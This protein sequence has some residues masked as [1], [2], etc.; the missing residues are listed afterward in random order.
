VPTNRVNSPNAPLYEVPLIGP[1]GQP[2]SIE[3]PGVNRM[4][5]VAINGDTLFLPDHDTPEIA[6]VD[7][8]GA[9]LAQVDSITLPFTPSTLYIDPDGQYLFALHVYDGAVSVV[10]LETRLVETTV[11]GLRFP[12][13]LEFTSDGRRAYVAEWTP[14]GG[15]TVIDIDRGCCLTG[16]PC[17]P[18]MGK[19]KKVGSTLP[20]KF[21][22]YYDDAPVQS[23]EELD[24][25]LVACGHEPACPMIRIC[26]VT[27]IAEDLGIELPPSSVECEDYL[28]IDGCFRFTE[29]GKCIYNLKLDAADGI[30][31]DRTYLVE[32]AI[33]D[34]IVKPDNF[35]FQTR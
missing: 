15:I 30:A 17:E 27:D 14:N 26:D 31:R 33:G 25:I 6:V 12:T 22:L 21:Q 35:L 20:V 3:I 4:L 34:I 1:I 24:A 7:R 11:N 9:T 23:Q 29:D 16:G 19:T 18:P 28:D 32:V 10:D 13:D 8:S 2:R 5:G